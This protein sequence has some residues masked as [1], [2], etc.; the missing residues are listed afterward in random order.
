[1]FPWFRSLSS[2]GHASPFSQRKN[3]Y[4][5]GVLRLT[6]T[7]F[8]C[9]RSPGKPELTV[10]ACVDSHMVHLLKN[11]FGDYLLAIGGGWCSATRH[12]NRRRKGAVFLPL[13]LQGVSEHKSP[14]SRYSTYLANTQ[15]FLTFIASIT[16]LWPD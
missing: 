9:H 6:R 10:R 15:L 7:Y 13:L 3:V 12:T 8:L 2:G 1:M 11:L 14:G 5:H 4:H 16:R